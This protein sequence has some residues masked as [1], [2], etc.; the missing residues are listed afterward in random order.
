[1]NAHTNL[2]VDRGPVWTVTLDRPERANALSSALVEQ[3]HAMLDEAEGAR[4][5][6]LVLRGN[7]RHFA[8]GFD[9]GGLADETDATLALRFLRVGTLLERLIA[10]PFTTVA[11]AE[12]AAIGAGADVVLA[13]DH[14][15]VDPSVKLRFPGSAFGV[16]LGTVRR[17]ELGD[18]WATGAPTDLADAL[19][20]PRPARRHHDTDA[21]V[22]ALAR[23]V[24]IPGIHSR[25][26]AYA[27]DISK[28]A[29]AR[30]KEIA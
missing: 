6:A 30:K 16:A 13:C 25:I 7:A 10:A 20:G 22:S 5:Q 2:V 9:L 18:A 29:Q 11:V 14:R 27:H 26:T 8:A 17:A 3:L 28:A 21:E 24:A 23:S 19:A 12:G 4:P 1:M 15:L